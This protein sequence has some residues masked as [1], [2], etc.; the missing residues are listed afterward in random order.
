VEWARRIRL[1]ARVAALE[2][3]RHLAELCREVA[4]LREARARP[5]NDAS[6]AAP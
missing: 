1:E 3:E 2:S 4:D 6:P 5:G